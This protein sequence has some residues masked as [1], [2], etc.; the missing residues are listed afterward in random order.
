MSE[1]SSICMVIVDKDLAL[2]PALVR[3]A[4]LAR[5]SGDRLLLALFEFDRALA[6]A[7]TRGL[8]LEAYL[9]GRREKLESLAEQLRRDGLTVEIHLF[10]YHPIMARTLLAVLAEHPTMVIKDVRR[11]GAL[12]R[13]LFTPAD[14]D[15]LRQCS[16]PLMLV[17]S[18]THGLPRRILA[19]V[20]PL[21]EQGR[22][23]ELTA[24]VL[25]AANRLAMQ[26]DAALDVVHA[27]EYMPPFADAEFGWLPDL[28]QIEQ[29]RALHRD[30]L[31]DLGKKFGI[32]KDRLHLLDGIPGWAIAE[33]AAANRVDVVVMGSVQR[34]FL[35][36]LSIGSVAEDLLQ[37]LDCDVLALKPEGFAERLRTELEPGSRAA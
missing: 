13:V 16:A 9:R 31:Q 27:F 22:P 17:R 21:D 29:F 24:R 1:Q 5:K 18:G 20:D 11:E 35:Q 26:C 14:L 4:A 8:D 19:A 36:R 12:K 15:L 2:T 37:R 7:A 33:F 30:A 23:H 25:N 28:G 6:H 34:N 10:W 32:P 3:A